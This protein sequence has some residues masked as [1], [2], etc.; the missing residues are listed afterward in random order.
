MA[1]LQ[2]TF[3]GRL[4]FRSHY[5]IVVHQSQIGYNKMHF[6]GTQIS[7]NH[8]NFNLNVGE[9]VK[10]TIYII[11]GVKSNTLYLKTQLTLTFDLLTGDD[12]HQ[13]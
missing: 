6:I 9:V 13:K 2:A 7:C 11:F 1:S 4:K 5:S 8:L 12:N 10:L 3:I